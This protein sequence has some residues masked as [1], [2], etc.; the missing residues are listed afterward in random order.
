[1]FIEMAWKNVWRN[2]KRSFV[3]LTSIALGL[4]GGIFATGAMI[5]MAESMV[6]T[7]IDRDLAHIQ[8]HTKAFKDNPLIQNCIPDADSLIA[9]LHR[10]PGVRG[11]TG[12]AKIEG[13]ASS[14]ATNSGV[15]I[16]GIDPSAEAS[17]TTIFKRIVEGN[18]LDSNRVNSAMIG[19]I[20]AEKLNLRLHSKLV[21]S[22]PGLDG[23][24]IYGAFRIT[25]IFQ[26]ES[27]LFDKSTVYV[28][29]RDISALL[30][31]PS[32]VHEIAIRLARADSVPSALASLRSAYPQ[33]VVES[34]KDLAPE[35][36]ITD[37]L[38]NVTMLFFLAII[39]IGLLFGITNTML[40]SVLDRVREFGM[41]M[42][43]GMKRKRVFVQIVLETG[44][45]SIVGSVVG[46]SA[47]IILIDITRRTGI[48]LSV[49]AE[50]LSSYGISPMLYPVLPLEMYFELGILIV[51]TALAAAIYPGIKATRLKP[52][53]AIRTYV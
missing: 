48:D 49:F 52:A 28:N 21:L 29:N 51:L 6:N 50:G 8:I 27:S 34:W 19:K 47:G 20:L 33:L 4:C 24:I 15:E 12:R 38:T 32:I 40:M 17:A 7:A 25:G 10:V 3:I 16:L 11:I 35:L 45:L 30:G 18:Y 5:G 26:T 13:M 43:I 41:V 42:A 46:V 23:S 53:E 22:F 39:L 37:E 14:P 44:L 9:E 36:K 31:V 2:K 1:M